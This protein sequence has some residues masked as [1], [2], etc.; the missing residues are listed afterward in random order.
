MIFREIPKSHQGV[1]RNEGVKLATTPY[2]LFSQDDIFLAPDACEKHL[3][4]L[5]NFQLPTQKFQTNNQKP[6][7]KNS[8]AV[9]GFTTWDPSLEI[10]P[11]MRWLEA[12]GWQFGYPQIAQYTHTFLPPKMQHKFTY[13]SHISLP[14]AIARAHPF[15]ED[16]TLYGWEDV[17]WG[18]R[19]ADAGVRLYY[20]PD[21]KAVHHHPLSLEQSLARM[22]TLGRAAVQ[23]AKLNPSFDRTPMGTKRILYKL[24]ALLPTM[25]GRHRKAFLKGL[26]Q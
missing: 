10:T 19:L 23:L 18:M 24:S 14:T 21:A 3:N 1:A 9:L 2:V 8:F 5:R 15:R 11:V 20:E 4:A 7:T 16:I 13:T 22:E 6:I 25:A 12:S 17:E 26:T